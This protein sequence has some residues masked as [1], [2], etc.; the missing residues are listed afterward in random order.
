VAFENIILHLGLGSFHRAHQAVYLQDLLDAGQAGWGLV[1]GNIRADM[2]AIEDGLIRQ[3]GRYTLETIT[4]AGQCAYRTISAISEVVPWDEALQGLIARGASPQCRI[5]SFTVT[6]AGYYLT[7]Q[8]T[9]DTGFADLVEDLER[10]GRRTIYGALAAI[11]SARRAAGAGPVTLL[12]CDNLRSNGD[13]FRAGFSAFL[14]QTG[15]AALLD[16]VE[17]NTSAPNSMVDRITPRPSAETIARIRRACGWADDCPVMAESFIQWVVEDHFVAGR[18]PWEQA[19]VQITDSVLPFEEAKIR[20]LNSSHSAIAW[21]GT[22]KGY[23]YIHEGALD[24]DIVR[25][26]HDYVT[27]DVIPVLTPSP[28]DL[29][30]YR[31]AVL[32]RFANPAIQDTNQRVAADGYSKIPGFLV[33]TFQQRLA[34]GDTVDSVAMLPALFLLFLRHWAEGRLDYA[35]QDQAMDEAAARLVLAD[36][37]PVRAFSESRLLWGEL[38]G[39]ARVRAALDAAYQRVLAQFAAG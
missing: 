6:E 20:I 26:A 25:I 38:A 4:P 30:T 23:K 28:I 2:R 29:P 16:W 8:N 10:G 15:D 7:P 12:S 21:A 19:G 34:G 35:Y 37:D 31:D 3:G 18:P 13:R 22:L 27:D 36:P 11:L 9:L 32:E 39:D 14:R 17:Q 33:P 24:P 5:I 1:G